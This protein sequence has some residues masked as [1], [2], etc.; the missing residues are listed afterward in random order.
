L[1]VS[2]RICAAFNDCRALSSA[3]QQPTPQREGL[4]GCKDSGQ[5]FLAPKITQVDH[6]SRSAEKRHVLFKQALL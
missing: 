4:P 2:V 5:C 3:L 6:S 1:D